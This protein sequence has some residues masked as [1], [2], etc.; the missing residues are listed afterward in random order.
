MQPATSSAGWIGSPGHWAPLLNRSPTGTVSPARRASLG[1]AEGDVTTQVLAR[2]PACWP[3]PRP[4]T[5][6]NADREMFGFPRLQRLV[7]RP[8]TGET[9]IA[10]LLTELD[11]FMSGE[12]DHDI[13]L[14]G[15]TRATA[16]AGDDRLQL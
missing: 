3:H 6:Y 8:G 4:R 5:R 9:M 10:S 15:L 14:L 16:P 11:Q 13:T 7:A 12:H 2:A 1:R